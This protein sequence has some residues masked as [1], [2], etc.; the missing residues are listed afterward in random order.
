MLKVFCKTCLILFLLTPDG[1]GDTLLVFRK[2]SEN[3]NTVFDSF[4]S[5]IAEDHNI[6][7]FIFDDDFSYENFKQEILKVKPR[8]LVLMDNLALNHAKKLVNEPDPYLNQ[9][10]GVATMALNLHL[11]LE[12]NNRLA[13]ISY[14]VPGFSVINGFRYLLK[15]KLQRVGVIYRK[16]QHQE[17]IE[18]A[19][20]QL[21]RVGIE[22]LAYDSEKKGKSRIRINSF[23]KNRLKTM[24]SEFDA[25]W[26][27]ADNVLLNSKAFNKYW[28]P[29]SNKIPF[30]CP[31]E[32]FV[33]QSMNFCVYSAFPAHRELGLQLAEMVFSILDGDRTVEE[34]G[35]QDIISVRKA[36]NIEKFRKFN[37]DGDLNAMSE[38][39][40]VEP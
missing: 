27:L 39:V 2:S 29:Q 33:Q 8:L 38:L 9:L 15:G 21:Q 5:E 36:I 18:Q 6:N 25:V 4:S 22:L 34:I 11:A 23:I 19:E 20:K 7:E 35:V 26:V 14:E 17:I 13:G 12:G 16:S 30:I 31:L 24:A 40:K 37:L 10:Q 32:K 3:F 1:K 28:L